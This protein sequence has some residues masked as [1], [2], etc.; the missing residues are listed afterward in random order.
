MQNTLESLGIDKKEIELTLMIEFLFSTVEEETLL[1]DSCFGMSGQEVNKFVYRYRKQKI[2]KTRYVSFSD[3]R[4]TYEQNEKKALA[5]LFQEYINE[6]KFSQLKCR[7]VETIY[8][9]HLQNPEIRFGR[10]AMQ[11]K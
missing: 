2:K 4:D 6:A 5:R 11:V 7:N 1:L 9:N 10:F 8:S 3:F